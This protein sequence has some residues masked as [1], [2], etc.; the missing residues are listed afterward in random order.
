M[1]IFSFV[2]GLTV[3]SNFTNALDC[4]S[5]KSRECKVRPKTAYIN[6][7]NA[8]FYYFSLKINR[9]SGNCNNINDPYARIC[10]PDTVKSLN[11]TVFDLMSRFNETKSIKWHEACTCICRLNKIVCNN[12]QK[13]NKGKWRCECKRSI[14]KG[15][16]DKGYIV[17]PNNCVCE[18]D[19]SCNVSQYLDYSSCKCKKKLIDPLIEKCAKN[20]DKTKIIN[21]TAENVNKTKTVNI[22]VENENSSCK[23]SIVLMAVNFTILT[24]INI[25]FVY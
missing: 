23:V 8:I 3:L 20:D 18:C 21:T 7:N 5:M 15:V 16:C 14:D 17:N 25:Y 9:Y 11:V 4:V 6:I 24:A 12:K 13:W 19:K 1:K 22:A 2:L 10:I